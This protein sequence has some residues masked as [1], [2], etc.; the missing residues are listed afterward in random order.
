M[1]ATVCETA[2]C[3]SAAGRRYGRASALLATKASASASAAT[4]LEDMTY[5]L[6]LGEAERS[7]RRERMDGIGRAEIVEIGGERVGG[8]LGDE[9]LAQVRVDADPERRARVRGRRDR[10]AERVE[11]GDAARLRGVELRLR[12]RR[13]V[14]AERRGV[15]E[16][17][18]RGA[19]R[20]AAARGAFL[21][22]ERDARRRRRVAGRDLVQRLV[23]RGRDERDAL[24]ARRGE[25]GRRA[26]A[27]RA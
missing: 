10:A 11:R 13:L 1:N 5:S 3:G 27:R 16:R 7:R 17:D 26:V 20:A 8:A 19:E 23:R 21:R 18:R 25:R 24:R 22:V 12:R 2:T 6:G 4:S 14:D 15:R 9:R